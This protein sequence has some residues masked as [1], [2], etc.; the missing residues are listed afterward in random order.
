MRVSIGAIGFAVVF[1]TLPCWAQEFHP[2]IPRAWDDKAVQGLEVPLA[3]RDRSPRYMNAAEYYKLKVRPIYRSYPVYVKGREPT[4]YRESLKQKEPEIIFDPSKLRTKADWIAAGKLVF[5]SDTQFRPAPPEPPAEGDV[6]VPVLKDGTFLAARYYIRKKGVLEVGRDSCAGCHTRLMAD[7][8]LLEGAQG[9]AAFGPKAAPL[10]VEHMRTDQFRRRLHFLWIDYGTPW[11]MS[12][13][14]L[15]AYYTKEEYVRELAAVVE[16]P[17]VFPRQGTSFSHPVHIPSLIGVQHRKYLDAT[18]LV[19]NRSIGDLMRYAILNEGMDTLAHFGD[20]QPSP[21]ATPFS[22]EEGTRYSDAELYALALY[23]Y[24]LKPPPNP[25][26]FDALAAR[27]QKVFDREGCA[28]CHTPPLYTNNKLTP[29]IGFKVPDDLRQTDDILDI[30]VGTEPYLA[31]K[32]RRGTGFY[33]V[34]S[35]QGVWFRN[36]FGHTGQAETLEEWFD[37]ARLKSDYVPKGFHLGPGPIQG[38]PFGLDLNPED[39]K[40]LIAFLKTL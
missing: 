26:K 35:L 27:G 38:H 2:N 15:E 4:G 14:Q 34:P 13:E 19:R 18:G 8:S 36:A 21:H 29:A 11:V 22:G 23:L 5:E 7:G 25:N 9:S 10:R 30:S 28:M 33:K 12:R 17:G 32:T 6:P 16:H 1:L 39:K 31:L 3:Q 20:F 40:A 24:S 37:P